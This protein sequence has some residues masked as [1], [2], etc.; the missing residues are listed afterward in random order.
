[1]QLRADRMDHASEF[2][3]EIRKRNLRY[4]EV[5]VVIKYTEY[6]KARGQSSWNAVRI[7]YKMVLHKFMR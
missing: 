2:I 7:L 4:K 1:M 6:S 3:D 5:P